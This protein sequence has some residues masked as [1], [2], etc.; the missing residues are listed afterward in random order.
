M[1]TDALLQVSVA[2]AITA[3]AVSTHTIPV[4]AV[5]PS[6]AGPLYATFTVDVAALAAG[7]ATV[8]F[9]VISSA[10]ANLSSPT[11]LA[12][13]DAIGKAELTVGRRPISLGCNF[14]NL[15]TGH[16][17]FGA[18]YV[19]GTGP[20]TAGSFSC[21]FTDT[22]VTGVGAGIYSATKLGA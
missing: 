9:Q 15:P 18:Q 14:A 8:N 3:T 4:E 22:A 20:L 1:N 16:K 19:V 5:G 7:A 6:I 17:Y 2:Q 11:V 12:Q 21:A 10:S 13:T